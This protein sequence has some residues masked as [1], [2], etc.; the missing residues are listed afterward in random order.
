ML[1]DSIR[2]TVGR[3]WK[4]VGLGLFRF[5]QR[6]VKLF[7]L[8]TVSLLYLMLVSCTQVVVL[9]PLQPVET[10]NPI[11]ISGKNFTVSK[12][13]KTEVF[14]PW[15]FNYNESTLGLLEDKW[16]KESSWKVIE[17]DFQEMRELGANV[18]RIHLQ[19]AKF[20]DSPSQANRTSLQRLSRLV[21]IAEAKGLYLNITGLGA[22]R[23]A[24]TPSW[25][26]NLNEGERW[27]AQTVFWKSIAAQVGDSPSIFCYDLMNEPV[28]ANAKTDDWL[29]GDGI[30]GYHFVQ[31]ISI[32]RAGRNTVSIMRSWMLT[33]TDAIR[34]E[35]ASTPIT[36]GFL[37]F[38]GYKAYAQDLDFISV[39]VYP[40]RGDLQSS[41]DLIDNLQTPKPLLIEET[42]N[43]HADVN[44][45]EK[46][47]LATRAKTSGV[48]G[49]YWGET[50][51]ELN[52]S[53]SIR[54]ALM[55][56]FLIMFVKLNPNT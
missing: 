20:M 14:T 55:K 36:V 11:E 12:V 24:D 50:I 34:Q 1:M 23:K 46:F 7:K 17:N 51:S 6:P 41:I 39:H 56:N 27:A 29:P 43:L 2:H 31:N 42:F 53:L 4:V 5:L 49:F 13:G 35:D 16:D 37:P 18:V 25:Y 22:Y 44:D 15:G 19:F 3:W 21:S 47:I 38:A 8:G 54:D 30:G 33:M 28:V 52:N 45:L 32:D 9:P 26:N 10:L 40:K 48:I